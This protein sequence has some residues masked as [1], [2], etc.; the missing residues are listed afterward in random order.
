MPSGRGQ[1]LLLVGAAAAR[2]SI[3]AEG[4]NPSQAPGSEAT[5]RV[6]SPIV[7]PP[8]VPKA[9]ALLEA[10]SDE[11]SGESLN[12]SKWWPTM[13]DGYPGS[14]PGFNLASNAIVSDGRLQLFARNI[15]QPVKGS[16][17]GYYNV[18]TSAV[19]TKAARVAGYCEINARLMNSSAIKSSF[20][21]NQGRGWAGT[22]DEYP[23]RP[24]GAVQTHEIQT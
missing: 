4:A 1:L 6:G 14:L 3:V 9:W 17:P 20:W 15:A 7:P 19:G 23:L 2:P 22:P 21:F 18:T 5:G 10:M 24:E 16:P 11:F 13:D 8:F 12:L